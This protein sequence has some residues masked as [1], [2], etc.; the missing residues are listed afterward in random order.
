MAVLDS[1][2]PVDPANGFPTWYMDQKGVALELCVNTNAAVLAAG[3]CAV[4][5]GAPPN[6]V[7]TVPE[8]FP[9]NWST[10]HFYTLASVKLTS[11]GLDKLTG[12]PVGAAE[13]A[14]LGLVN[15]VVAPEALTAETMALAAVIA[16][17]SPLTLKIGKEAF[18]AQA[19]MSLDEAYRLTTRVMVENM[20]ARDAEEGIS[21]FIEKRH[22]VWEGR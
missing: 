16:S 18:Y 14:R 11:A 9:A 2:G 22:P 7:L 6:G 12:A 20:L 1:F 4:L 10:E 5:P 15:R 17:K 13:A 3:G 21:A 8:V 19:E